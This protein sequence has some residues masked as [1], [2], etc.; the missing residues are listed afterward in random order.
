MK[1]LTKETLKSLSDK[2]FYSLMESI[3]ILYL[4]AP[5]ELNKKIEKDLYLCSTEIKRR[6]VA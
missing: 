6:E 4:R 2:G 5:Y 1:Q 3:R